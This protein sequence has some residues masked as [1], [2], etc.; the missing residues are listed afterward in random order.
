MVNK[1]TIC[2]IL[3]RFRILSCHDTNE[4]DHVVPSLTETAS[5]D[6]SKIFRTRQRR[7]PTNVTHKSVSNGFVHRDRHNYLCKIRALDVARAEPTTQS[8]SVG[9]TDTE[10]TFSM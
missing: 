9:M 6:F 8:L 4:S 7:V 5:G 1:Y 2:I 3:V 10:S